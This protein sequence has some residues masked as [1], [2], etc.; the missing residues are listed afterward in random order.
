MRLID[1]DALKAKLSD[2]HVMRGIGL[3]PVAALED[4]EAFMDSSPTVDAIPLQWLQE[5]DDVFDNV[6]PISSAIKSWKA[7]QER[8]GQSCLP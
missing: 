5:Y 4:M 8:H 7:E 1:A 6:L 3:Q 2:M